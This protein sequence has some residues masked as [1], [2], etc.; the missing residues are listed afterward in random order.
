MWDGSF[1]TRMNAG[2][3]LIGLVS[4]FERQWNYLTNGDEGQFEG[5]VVTT[6][7]IS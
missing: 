4:K 5:A 3:A 1:S 7:H 6:V 2:D